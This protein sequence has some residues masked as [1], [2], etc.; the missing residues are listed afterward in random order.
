MRSRTTTLLVA[1]VLALG[2]GTAP[3]TANQPVKEPLEIHNIVEDN[4]EACGFPVR[5]EINIWGH[6]TSFFDGDGNLVRQQGLLRELNTVTNLDTGL[7]LVEGPDSFM[8]RVDIEPDGSVTITTAGL[9]LIIHAGD[10][11]V[12]D[13]GRFVV[14]GGLEGDVLFMAGQNEPRSLLADGGFTAVLA[15]F[16]DVLS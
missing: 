11:S 4:G 16:C 10:E 15:A 1:I 2:L 14:S 7:T 5:W 8:Q 6:Q 9:S 12:R 13:V 3:A